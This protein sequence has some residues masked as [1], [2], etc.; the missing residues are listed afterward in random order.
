MVNVFPCLLV[1]DKIREE[2]RGLKQA[3]HA[4]MAKEV[5]NKVGNSMYLFV[6]CKRV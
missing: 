4:Q 1:Q 6:T 2:E 3:Y 5:S